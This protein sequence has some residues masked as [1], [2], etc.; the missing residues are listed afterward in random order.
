ML[1]V[2]TFSPVDRPTMSS[3]DFCQ[4][5]PSPLD[6]GSTRQIDRSPR[7][8]RIHLHTYVCRIYVPA[9]RAGIGL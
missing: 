5:I 3:A 8:M 6:D 7:V 1:N 9:F 2:Q 4:P